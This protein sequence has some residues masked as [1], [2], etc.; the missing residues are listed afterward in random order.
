MLQLHAIAIDASVGGIQRQ[1]LFDVFMTHLVLNQQQSVS[2]DFVEG[3]MLTL[4]NALLRQRM[5]ACDDVTGAHRTLRPGQ[6]SLIAA[7]FI[8]RW[9]LF[10]SKKH[11]PT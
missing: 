9:S 6:K 10:G 4:W 11:A 1:M 8:G 5:D 7:Q 2:H 3:M